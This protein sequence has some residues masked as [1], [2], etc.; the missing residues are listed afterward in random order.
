MFFPEIFKN[1]SHYLLSFWVTS[2]PQFFSPGAPNYTWVRLLDVFP[3]VANA[4]LEDLGCIFQSF[5]PL[6]L[7]WGNLFGYIYCPFLFLCSVC[8]CTS[9]RQLYDKS[10]QNLA[11]WNSN[12]YP[13]A[14]PR[15][16][17][18]R[19]L[20]RLQSALRLGTRSRPGSPGPAKPL[21]FCS[22]DC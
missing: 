18:S 20:P 21:Q 9:Y 15:G 14:P 16:S 6:C 13:V 7:I 12:V 22:R 17:G 3:H 1:F 5:S 4:S 8:S 19:S 11:A 2:Q 10:L